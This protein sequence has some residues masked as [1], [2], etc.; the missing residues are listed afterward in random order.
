MCPDRPQLLFGLNLS[1]YCADECP[2][3]TFGDNDTRLCLD[4][5]VF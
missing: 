5:C 3:G 1:N 4:H 2:P